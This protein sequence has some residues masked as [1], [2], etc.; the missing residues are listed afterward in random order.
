MAM[1]YLEKLA[2]IGT[3]RL[4]LAYRKNARGRMIV[5]PATIGFRD[6]IRMPGDEKSF[7]NYYIAFDASG[8][9]MG[10]RLRGGMEFLG[11]LLRVA[12]VCHEMHL[13]CFDRSSDADGVMMAAIF[14]RLIGLPVVFHDYGF[15]CNGKDGHADAWPALFRHVEYGDGTAGRDYAAAAPN[16]SYRYDPVDISC[17]RKFA[18]DTAVPRVIVY[19]DFGRPGIIS[20]AARCHDMV[21]QKYPRTEFYLVSLAESDSGGYDELGESANFYS[22]R[23]DMEM[24]GLFAEADCVMLLSPGGVNRMFISRARAAG[25]PVVVNGL[26]YSDLDRGGGR[27]LAAAR[28][29]YSGLAG[30]VISLVDDED[31]YR[32]FRDF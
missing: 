1:S 14:A 19:G 24:Q 26:E 30:A 6:L 17:Y 4:T 22:P 20:L 2:T 21:K 13:Y 16:R 27:Y 31:H 5:Y 23:N 18:K 25:F 29:S 7:R 15:L 3:G 32:S 11:R 28:G 10:R 9:S 8:M 12:P